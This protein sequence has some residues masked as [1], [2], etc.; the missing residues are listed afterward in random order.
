LFDHNGDNVDV[1]NIVIRGGV[2]NEYTVK[3]VVVQF[4]SAFARLF[5]A[6]AQSEYP[7]VFEVRTSIEPRL[8]GSSLCDMVD[9]PVV[10]ISCV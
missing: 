8:E 6:D 10:K 2:A 4:G 1:S 3:V 5:N 9:T 7:K